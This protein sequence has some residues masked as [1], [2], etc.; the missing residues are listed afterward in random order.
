MIAPS[1]LEAVRQWRYKP[2]ELDKQPV[3]VHT[4]VTVTYTAGLFPGGSVEIKQDSPTLVVQSTE[5]SS[6]TH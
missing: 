3:E 1:A 5:G 6:S 2:F 4:V